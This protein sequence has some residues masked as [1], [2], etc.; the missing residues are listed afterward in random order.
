MKQLTEEC[1]LHRGAFCRAARAQRDRPREVLEPVFELY[2]ALTER[3]I[4]P[5][6]PSSQGAG[7]RKGN[8]EALSRVLE[9]F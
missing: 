7:L 9:I 8:R 6:N 1:S 2:G 3:K 4:T 5:G